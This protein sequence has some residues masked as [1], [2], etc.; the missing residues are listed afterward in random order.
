[1]EPICGNFN[2]EFIEDLSKD[3]YCLQE[4]ENTFCV[5]YSVNEILYLVYSTIDLSIIFY[6]IINKVKIVEIKKAH[7]SYIIEFRHYL[8]DIEK[9]KKRDLVLSSSYEDRNIKIW[10]VNNMECI[11][12]INPYSKG[13][14]YSSCFL[15]DNYSNEILIATSNYN[16][17]SNDLEPIKVFHLQG[18]ELK[19]INDSNYSTIFI[20]S[21]Y[22]EEYNNIFIIT[23]NK[24]SVISYDYNENAEYH[25]YMQGNF[26]YD[27]TSIIIYN[28]NR[29]IDDKIK[30]IYSTGNGFIRV[31][32]FHRG[33]FLYEIKVSEGYIFSICLLDDKYL[34]S[35]GKYYNNEITKKEDK[36]SDIKMIHINGEVTCKIIEHSIFGK[37][38][39]TKNIADDGPIKLWK[40]RT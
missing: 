36:Q 20:D 30:I 22:D 6:D 39:V 33:E 12:N 4:K 21:F 1:M 40:I 3:V 11:F 26:L 15:Y 27:C 17:N 37:F 32:D 38:L 29:N 25:K 14:I 5:F 10:D 16:N 8:D 7:E 13:I 24:Y 23:A 35:C 9:K 19:E 28:K 2:I 34:F 18:E 31:W